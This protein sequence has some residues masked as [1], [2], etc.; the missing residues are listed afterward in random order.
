MSGWF[1]IQGM[2]VLAIPLLKRTASAAIIAIL[3]SASAIAAAGIRHTAPGVLGIQT[4]SD[5]IDFRSGGELVARYHIGRDLAKPYFWPINGPAGAAVTRGWPMEKAQPGGSTDHPHQKSAW[6]GHGDII[7]EGI[8]LKEKVKG[9]RG[10]DFW[11]EAKGHGRI[12][13]TKV[14]EPTIAPDY[15]QITTHNEWQTADGVKMLDEERTLQLYEVAGAPL[16]V[17]EVELSASAVPVIF[18]DTKEGTFGVRVND[19]MR[20]S[21][22]GRIENADGKTGEFAC[23]GR[24]SAWCDDSGT[25]AGKTVGIALFD[26]PANAF[27]A[28][29]HCRGYGLMAANPFGRGRSG[30]P[31]VV[32]RSDLVRLARGETLRL[33]Y[34]LFIHI[35]DA[36]EGLVAEGYHAFVL[37]HHKGTED[38]KETQRKPEEKKR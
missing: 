11:S 14:G 21:K 30:F 37:L 4:A 7:P 16:L 8:V 34:G 35:G 32:G 20:A 24:R 12:V 29:W 38:T 3:L 23:W 10:V 6:F 22:G 13:C 36:K 1:S 18:G 5:H 28:C 17:V 31:A 26:D 27:A 15:A 9:V 2:D 25:V 33:R 19:A